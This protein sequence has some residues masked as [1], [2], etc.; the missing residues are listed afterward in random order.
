MDNKT[1]YEFLLADL[2]SLKGVGNKTTALLRK[3]KLIIFLIFYGNY[4]S[5]IQI[6]AYQLKLMI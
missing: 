4:P 2:S 6:E 5:L 1:N 3:K